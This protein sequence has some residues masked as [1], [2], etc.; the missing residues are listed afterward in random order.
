MAQIIKKTNGSPSQNFTHDIIEVL[1]QVFNELGFGYQEKY[2]YRAIK[3]KLLA[4]GFKVLEQLL[5]KITVEGKTIGRYFLDFLVINKNDEKV[6]LELKVAEQVYP[7]HIRQVLGYLKAN[8]LKLGI[9]AVYST[10][11]VIIKRVIN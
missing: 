3:L 9:I 8:N 11:G 5:T 1:F 10:R 7:Q 2:H 4:K 6:V